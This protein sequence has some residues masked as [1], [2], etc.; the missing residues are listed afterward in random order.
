[1]ATAQR[2]R[3]Y[4]MREK[5]TTSWFLL[6]MFIENNKVSTLRIKHGYMVFNIVYVSLI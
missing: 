4:P 6:Q 5:T 3:V 2:R 1:M